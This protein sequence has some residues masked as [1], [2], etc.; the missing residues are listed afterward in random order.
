MMFA[1]TVTIMLSAM[2]IGPQS[3]PTGGDWG[4]I[5]MADNMIVT[6]S[7]DIIFANGFD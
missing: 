7:A 3:P 4:P 1:E 2:K 6:V 5:F